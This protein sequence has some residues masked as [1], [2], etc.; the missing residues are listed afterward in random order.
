[1]VLLSKVA[2]ILIINIPS[3]NVL[4][5]YQFE[6]CSKYDNMIE[7]MVLTSCLDKS[8]FVAS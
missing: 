2:T 6:L 8:Y 7:N 3:V 4:E 1:M 5:K